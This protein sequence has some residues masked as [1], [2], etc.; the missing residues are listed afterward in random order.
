MVSEVLV[1]PLGVEGDVW[2]VLEA[3]NLAQ[4]FDNAFGEAGRV[5]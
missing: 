3:P 1:L 4:R 2:A 5:I